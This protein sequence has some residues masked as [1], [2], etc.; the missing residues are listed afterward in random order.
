MSDKAQS[1]L[2]NRLAPLAI[3]FAERCETDRRE[4]LN[5]LSKPLETADIELISERVHRLAGSA[6]ILG[7]IDLGNHASELDTLL[8]EDPDF[9]LKRPGLDALC[10]LLDL[11][12]RPAND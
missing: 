4:I 2:G 5:A 6:A 11:L 10:K 1:E 7:F 8:S 12:P 3:R 9:L